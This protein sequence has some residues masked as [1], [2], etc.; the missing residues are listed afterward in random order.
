MS[1]SLHLLDDRIDS[2]LS[3]VPTLREYLIKKTRALQELK[4]KGTDLFFSAP[5]SDQLIA[6]S[7]LQP[8]NARMK[9][10]R[11]SATGFPPSTRPSEARPHD[12]QHD[13]NEKSHDE[14]TTA[15]APGPVDGS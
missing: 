10:A 3:R 8:P 6:G 15:P 4:K 13:H 14:T 1:L 12:R 5:W 9:P 2:S 7:L 11:Q